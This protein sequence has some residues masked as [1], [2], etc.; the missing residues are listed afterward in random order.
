MNTRLVREKF[1]IFRI[2]LVSECSSTIVMVRL[3]ENLHIEKD[4]VMQWHTHAMNF[5]TNLKVKIDLTL[6]T[7]ST[8][9]VVTRICH[10]D[11]STKGRYDIILGQYLLT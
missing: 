3:A 10:A 5:N 2:L 6:P 4:D 8:T 9:N 7:L 1:K 11:D